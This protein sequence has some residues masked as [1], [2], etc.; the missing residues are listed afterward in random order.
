M[1]TNYKTITEAPPGALT[2]RDYAAKIGQRWPHYVYVAYNRYLSGKGKY[3]GYDLV[4][5]GGV[6]LVIPAP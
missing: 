2:V 5:F 6:A 3:P 1:K 4:N